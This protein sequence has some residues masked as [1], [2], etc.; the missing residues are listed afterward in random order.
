MSSD[1]GIPGTVT[2]VMELMDEEVLA[3]VVRV[4]SA[5]AEAMAMT[6]QQVHS[7]LE[8]EGVDVTLSQVKKAA[9][10][11]RKQGLLAEC[12]QR[13]AELVVSTAPC[14]AQQ[15]A[16]I[17]TSAVPV[18]L[19]SMPAAGGTGEAP[20]AQ[21]LLDIGRDMLLAMLNQL[22][23]P[24]LAIASGVCRALRASALED[25]LPERS[26]AL[27]KPLPGEKPP[28]HE[29]HLLEEEAKRPKPPHVDRKRYELPI[30]FDHVRVEAA[31]RRL[32]GGYGT[33][34][35][36]MDIEAETATD[37][38]VIQLYDEA[39]AM[40]TVIRANPFPIGMNVINVG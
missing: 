5:S 13:L 40:E 15:S 28:L 16:P 26:A 19:S 9:S 20:A 29:L 24:D 32:L 31:M 17:W 36:Q 21:H 35:D 6:A 18:D 38:Q 2:L 30:L 4:K 33:R 7:A 11:A 12:E 37:E 34:L 25:V 22:P 39:I 23:T 10:K 14:A 8:A 27:S 1:P 3:H